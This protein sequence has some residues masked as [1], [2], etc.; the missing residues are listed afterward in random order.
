MT[1]PSEQR[2]ESPGP[3]PEP[4]TAARASAADTLTLAA[5]FPAATKQQWREKVRAVLVKAGRRGADTAEAPE[6]L[7]ARNTY[8]GIRI[9]PL[10]TAEDQAPPAGFPGLPPFVRGGAPEGHVAAGWDLRGRY[11]EPAADTVNAA[12]LAD[13]ENGIRSLWLVTGPEGLPVD[14]LEAALNG[15]LLDLAPVTLEPTGS[16]DDVRAAV[17]ALLALHTKRGIPAS[18]VGGNL[19][20][21]PIGRAARSGGEPALDLLG[22]AAE[23][24]HA[25]PALR[26]VVVDALPYH[27]AGGSDAQELAAAVAT[28]VTYLR[29]LTAA[30]LDINTAARH[31][32]FRYATTDEQFAGIAKLRAARRLW[33]RVTEVS[34]AG[35][36]F[37][38]ARIHA[39]TSAPMMTRRDPWVNM[40][41]GTVACF[42]AGIGGAD[43][44]TVAPFDAALGLPSPFSRRIARN[45][46]VI[47]L[48]ESK[49]AG[50]IDPAGGSWY[51]E[52][53]TDALAREAW[54]IFTEIERAGGIV[55]ELASGRI[56]EQLAQTWVKRSANIAT[57]RDAITGVSEFPNLTEESVDRPAAPEQAGGGLPRVR[58]AQAFEALR[59]ASDAELARTGHRPA[60]FLATIGPVAAHTARATFAANLFAAG[61]IE[62]PSAGATSVVDEIVAAFTASGLPVACICGTDTAYAEQVA[63]LASALKAAGATR[64][65]LAGPRKPEYTDAGVDQFIYRGCPALDVLTETLETLAI[66]PEA[67][68]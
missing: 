34:G 38:A 24:A 16:P 45:T 2:P 47:L 23:H 53:R 9:A 57:R 44:V 50:V 55:A 41:R 21:D 54:R 27:D 6:D 66:H 3:S 17:G 31:I 30:G 65:V 37:R 5:E 64:V 11:A 40:L 19:G 18:E 12:M 1:V 48:E 35:P 68:K 7:I 61:G 52:S 4:A 62:T 59:D 32:E 49:L 25:Y 43:A 36:A 8:D 51:V 26:T 60:V 42:S 20:I 13:L 15:V 58:Y 33:A 10:Y 67:E 46:Q 63:P 56:A 28:A 39:V 22:T 14:A 29:G